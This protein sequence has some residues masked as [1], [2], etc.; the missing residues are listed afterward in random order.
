MQN[1]SVHCCIHKLFFLKN[2]TPNNSW[3][4]KQEYFL[5]PRSYPHP[6]SQNKW[7]EGPT[8]PAGSWGRILVLTL[9]GVD[10]VS[11]ALTAET[12]PGRGRWGHALRQQC[13]TSPPSTPVSPTLIP[14]PALS[15]IFLLHFQPLCGQS[16]QE[17]RNSVQ[18]C[19][20]IF[21]YVYLCMY[22]THV[23]TSA[24]VSCFSIFLFK[25]RRIFCKF[26]QLSIIRFHWQ[27]CST[28][29]A[30]HCWFVGSEEVKQ[31]MCFYEQG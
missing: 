10:H 22:Y 29:T 26:L 28:G 17:H 16:L 4:S 13:H 14:A 25:V 3:D 31:E 12:G 30:Q 5:I 6:S 8:N 23:Y 1:I 15:P 9:S 24:T 18:V 27:W 11:L 2:W 19:T 21:L 20:Q 7:S